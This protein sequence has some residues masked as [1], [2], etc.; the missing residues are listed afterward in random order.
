MLRRR[1]FDYENLPQ[2]TQRRAIVSAIIGARKNAGPL[3]DSQRDSQMEQRMLAAYPFDPDLL[4]IF[5]TKWT[6]LP[7][8]QRT[9]GALRL[10]AVALRDAATHDPQILIGPGVFLSSPD[11][12]SLSE[13]MG[14]LCVTAGG[15]GNVWRPKIEQELRFA[16]EIQV[17]T[18]PLGPERDIERAVMGT[19]LHSQPQ[20]TQQ[21]A[22]MKDLWALLV[23]PNTDL[24]ALET[25]LDEWRHRSWF[26]AEDP[27]TWRLTTLPNLK[28]YLQRCTK[29]CHTKDGRRRT[30]KAD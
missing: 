5:Y 22:E 30:A 11:K 14:E 15:D 12:I 10:L 20:E 9:R 27:A 21:R 28:P 24:S 7:N 2:E 19:F 3:T 8:F 13:A 23:S 4:N 25:G 26:L 17:E 29:R 18:P 1:L 16:R 6:S